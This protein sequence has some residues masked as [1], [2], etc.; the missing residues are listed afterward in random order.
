MNFAARIDPTEINTISG[1]CVTQLPRSPRC[2]RSSPFGF[3][4]GGVVAAPYP[5]SRFGRAPGNPLEK[6]LKIILA[7]PLHVCYRVSPKMSS[8]YSIKPLSPVVLRKFREWGRVGGQRGSRADKVRAAKI[9]WRPGGGQRQRF[10][11]RQ[12]PQGFFCEC[13]K[14]HAFNAAVEQMMKERKPMIHECACGRQ[15]TITQWKAKLRRNRG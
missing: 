6:Y 13:G 9:A 8:A 1:Q 11:N 7:T 14:W 15:H 12:R 4:G 2:A 10:D 5:V 3:P